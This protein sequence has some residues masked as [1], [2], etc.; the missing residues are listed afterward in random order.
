MVQDRELTKDL[1]LLCTGKE[2]DALSIELD[3]FCP[4]EAM[5]VARHEIRHSNF[6]AEIL[7]PSRPHGFDESVLRCFVDRIL[8]SEGDHERRLSIHLLDLGS[9]EILREWNHI[10]LIIYFPE[11]EDGIVFALELKIEA[12]E[13]SDQLKKYESVVDKAWPSAEKHFFVLSAFDIDPTSERW[14]AL[15]FEEII[16]AFDVL[17]SEK[18]GG[19]PSAR[20]LL[21]AYIEMMRRRYLPN[22]KLERIAQRIW[23]KHAST[24]E[25]LI[26]QRPNIMRDASMA[27]QASNVISEIAETVETE[28]GIRIQQ[29]SSSN[30]YLRFFVPAWAENP[31]MVAGDL[32]VSGHLLICEVEFYGERI[33]IRMMI[34]KG[35]PGKRELL[36]SILK[37]HPDVDTG[38]SKKLTGQ[39][40]RLA[41]K[42]IKRIKNI[43]ELSSEEDLTELV[44]FTKKEIA[45]FLKKHL[46]NFNDALLK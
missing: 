27:V 8:L 18:G 23:R 40:T 44:E 32:T 17:L 1:A 2:F 43:D 42:T 22:E 30:T 16:D 14:H 15:S 5:K 36:Y 7:T 33:H 12:K 24:L 26:G 35:D 19:H 21:R 11:I 31:H 10:D 28:S 38:R 9:T 39:Y 25:Y 3:Q 6:L 34:S 46:P 29:D 37:D 45:A 41:S 13:H 20:N 4:F